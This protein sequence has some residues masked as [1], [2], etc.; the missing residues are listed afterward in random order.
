M[1]NLCPQKAKAGCFLVLF[2]TIS[3]GLVSET[4]GQKDS[5][6]FPLETTKPTDLE[7]EAAKAPP[8]LAAI[9]RDLSRPKEQY[10]QTALAK[11]EHLLSD[12]FEDK[13]LSRLERLQAAEKILQAAAWHYQ[14]LQERQNEPWDRLL[15]KLR[16]VRAEQLSFLVSTSDWPRALPLADR[17]LAIYPND[18]GMGSFCRR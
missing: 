9:Y 4:S 11:V 3:A 7:R 14:T 5:P 13:T 16:S 6:A 2:A 8:A 10:E 12:G 17:L 1:S 18:A 15:E